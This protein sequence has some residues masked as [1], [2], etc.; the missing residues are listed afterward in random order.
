MW[1]TPVPRSTAPLATF[2]A[3]K[4]TAIPSGSKFRVEADPRKGTVSLLKGSDGTVHFVWKDR[5]T[6][7]IEGDLLMSPGDQKLV[8]IETG[9]PNDRVYLLTFESAV[10]QRH[11]FWMQE[12]DASKDEERI[13]EFNDI[14]NGRQGQARGGAAAVQKAK[15]EDGRRRRE[16]KA[17]PFDSPRVT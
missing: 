2:K 6:L 9:R 12:P 16:C 8:K 13:R 4:M 11:F 10:N 5:T 1:S 17:R 14:M 7:Q 3:G 15:E